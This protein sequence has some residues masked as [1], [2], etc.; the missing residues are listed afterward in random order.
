MGRE[1]SRLGTTTAPGT[2]RARSAMNRPEGLATSMRPTSCI[3]K[4]PS[5]WVGPKRFFDGAQQAEGVGAVPL[6]VEH[7]VHQVLQDHGAGQ[8]A[9]L[10]DVADHK[11]GDVGELGV[12]HEAEG[13]LPHLGQGTRRRRQGGGVEGLDGIHREIGR[14]HLL[15]HLQDVFEAG[16]GGHQQIGA[17]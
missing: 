14:A 15:H 1:P 9:L 8:G 10:G 5:S 6:E 16:L 12:L 4:T 7:R 2:S 13:R 11:G 3:S 17:T